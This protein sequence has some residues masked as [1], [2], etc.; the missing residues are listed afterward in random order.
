MYN[1][2]GDAC[3][4]MRGHHPPVR[5]PIHTLVTSGKCK[6]LSLQEVSMNIFNVPLLTWKIF[7]YHHLTPVIMTTG[8]IIKEHL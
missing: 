3:Q 5:E 2:N 4:S 7:F 8:L 6:W 1:G